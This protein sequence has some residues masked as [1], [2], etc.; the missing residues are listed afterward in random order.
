MR[1]LVPEKVCLYFVLRVSSM[2]VCGF[3]SFKHIIMAPSSS[4]VVYYYYYY[5]YT[6]ILLII[7]IIDDD[8]VDRSMSRVR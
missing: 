3:H 7:I 4:I 2:G 6:V 8:D 5:Y 1:N